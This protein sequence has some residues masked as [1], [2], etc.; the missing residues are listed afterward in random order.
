MNNSVPTGR[1]FMKF[2][3]FPK[4][5][6]R[7]IKFHFNRTIMKG[8]LH[9]ERNTFLIIS[10]SVPKRRSVSV[11]SVETIEILILCSIIFFSKI[12][13]FF[14][15]MWKNIVDTGRHCMLDN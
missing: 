4:N 1:V 6:S 10:R 13:P 12:V 15:I 3:Y 8:T 11:K 9:E 7:K 14:E 2:E 5:L